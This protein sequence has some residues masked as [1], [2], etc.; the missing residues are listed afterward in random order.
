MNKNEIE[1]SMTALVG[2]PLWAVGRAAD[3]AWFQFGSR[4]AVKGWKGEEK[5]VGEWAL[6]VQCPWRITRAETIVTGRGDIFCTPE[7][8]N[9]PTPADFNWEKGN[10]FDRIAEQLFGDGSH[11]FSVQCIELGDAGA[12]EIRLEHDYKL[13]VFPQDSESAEHWRLFRP[14]VDE[15]HLVFSGRGFQ[16]AGADMPVRP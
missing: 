3:L 2:L 16:A 8:T 13:Q 12:I 11:E 14:Y 6:H 1:N 4:R 10:R 5:I 7:E 15:R 9:E